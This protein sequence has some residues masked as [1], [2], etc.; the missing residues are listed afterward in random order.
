MFLLPAPDIEY[1][2]EHNLYADN[3]SSHGKKGKEKEYSSRL[4]I[5]IPSRLEPFIAI[6]VLP[7][8]FCA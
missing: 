2:E 5:Y 8:A 6:T 1:I 4:S 7:Q 3:A